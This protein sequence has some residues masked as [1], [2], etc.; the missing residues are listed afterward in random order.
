MAP[1]YRLMFGASGLREYVAGQLPSG[2]PTL[3][4]LI[5]NFISL[6]A[7]YN[8]GIHT[9]RDSFPVPPD[10]E[11]VFELFERCGYVERVGGKVR[12]TDRIA[13]EMRAAYAWTEDFV[14]RSEAEDVEIDKMWRS[15][16]PRF[17]EMFFSGGPVDVV[18]LGIVISQFWYGGDWRDTALDAGKGEISLRDPVMGKAS[19]L[20]KKFR[21]SGG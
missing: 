2:A 11:R 16:P 17:R 1:C 6:V 14:S 5:E 8:Y 4:K 20:E 18:S 12:W 9:R 13:P 7:E 3:S 21:E 15:M 10:F 19:K